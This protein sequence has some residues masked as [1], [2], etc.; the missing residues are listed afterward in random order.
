MIFKFAVAA[1][2]ILLAVLAVKSINIKEKS[3]VATTEESE[4]ELNDLE[5]IDNLA[6][7]RWRIER[8]NEMMLDCQTCDPDRLHK[9]IKITIAD[10]KHEYDFVATGTNYVSAYLEDMIRLER[11]KLNRSLRSEVRKIK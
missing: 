11:E 7:M 10:N 8:L 3:P 5:I 1:I 2:Y 6:D 9:T 4:E